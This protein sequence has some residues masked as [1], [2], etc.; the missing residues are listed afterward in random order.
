NSFNGS[1]GLAVRLDNE[2]YWFDGIDGESTVRRKI[3]NYNGTLDGSI[4]PQ[5]FS[6]SGKPAVFIMGLI[7]QSQDIG[8][9]A[10][11]NAV[12]LDTRGIQPSLSRMRIRGHETG[13]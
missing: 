1:A 4:R 13:M 6:V 12:T 10:W 11:E 7:Y 2:L 8:G 5:V 3:G 9:Q